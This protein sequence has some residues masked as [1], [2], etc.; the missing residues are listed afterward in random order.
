MTLDLESQLNIQ[1]CCVLKKK[2]KKRAISIWKETRF[3]FNSEG[4]SN[5]EVTDIVFLLLRGRH[6]SIV[7]T[8]SNFSHFYTKPPIF[9]GLR[10]IGQIY[11][12]VNIRKFEYLDI[13]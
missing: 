8:L 9:T 13:V 12:I 5:Q 2:K 7:F 1:L 4:K 11:V 10:T 6:K 3:L